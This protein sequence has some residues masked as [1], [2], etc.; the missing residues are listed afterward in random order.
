MRG[1]I[2]ALIDYVRF[3]Y[4]SEWAYAIGLLGIVAGLIG[5]WLPRSLVFWASA[6]GLAITL[7]LLAKDT[8]SLRS[9][10]INVKLLNDR[11]QDTEHL[12]QSAQWDHE[13]PE[14]KFHKLAAATINDRAERIWR[15]ANVDRQLWVASANSSIEIY[16]G[17][18][19][20]PEELREIAPQS[21]RRT[22]RPDASVEE[23][24]H[25]PTWFNGK[26]CRLMTEPTAEMLSSGRLRLQE[27]SYF[28]GQSSNELWHWKIAVAGGEPRPVAHNYA[29]D[30]E[31][32]MFSLG[33][34][35]MANIVG[36]TIF[37]ITADNQVLFVQQSKKNSVL[38]GGIVASASGSL[39]W[40]DARRVAAKE[41]QQATAGPAKLQDVLLAGMLRE[42]KEESR[43]TEQDI[44]ADS[45]VVTGYFRWLSRGAKPE[46]TG[47][48]RLNVT[49]KELMN[50]KVR[51]DEQLYTEGRGKVPLSVLQAA[52]GS[53]DCAQ[54][55][56]FLSL[57]RDDAGFDLRFSGDEK[58]AFGASSA[59][60]WCAAADFLAAHPEYL[61][62]PAN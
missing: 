18:Y 47:L 21:L 1:R 5:A 60:A 56:L 16:R 51:R 4:G 57:R 62:A 10:W 33:D 14:A 59:A 30:T 3:V 2:R 58:I 20:L 42:L 40:A 49:F 26:L 7:L 28:D 53:W 55:E 54:E 8:L 52:A 29:A 50:R 9:R 41:K 23:R 22:S 17:R 43:V 61:S 45:A 34:S 36:V 48:V 12:F 44:I 37:A 11:T 46:F 24:T 27:V 35:R 19:H 39:D 32:R 13:L 6:L 31:G 15:D 25:R 38:P